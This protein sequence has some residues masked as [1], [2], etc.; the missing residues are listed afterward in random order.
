MI[1]QHQPRV[2]RL[3]KRGSRVR[4]VDTESSF[5]GATGTITQ[6]N[7]NVRFRSSYY[8][9]L[10]QCDPAIQ[11]IEVRSRPEQVE[12]LEDHPV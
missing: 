12:P 4:I 9:A 6:V 7:N 11:A 8:I 5:W 2:Q 1:Q 10:D 3:L